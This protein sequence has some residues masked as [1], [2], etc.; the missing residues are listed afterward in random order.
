VS[1]ETGSGGAARTSPDLHEADQIRVALR[2]R[3]M[4]DI[5]AA[6][7]VLETSPGNLEDLAAG[8]TMSPHEA[9]DLRP[10]LA[11]LLA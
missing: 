4:R 8:I 6:L 9:L 1:N 7:G 3:E 11:A 5:E 10:S 2:L